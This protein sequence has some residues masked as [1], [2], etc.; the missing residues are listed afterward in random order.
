MAPN[1]LSF[2]SVNAWN[3]IYSRRDGSPALPKDPIFF[4]EMLVDRETMTVANDF[5]HCRIRRSMAPAFSSRSMLEQEPILKKNVDLLIQ[6][7][8]KRSKEGSPIDLRIWYNYTTFDL[9]GDLAFGETF[10]CLEDSSCHEWVQFVLDYFYSATLLQ[11]VHRFYPLNKALY[12]LLPATLLENR[13]RHTCMALEKVRRRIRTKSSRPDFI[14]HMLK[15][16]EANL[17]TITE[18]E[19]QASIIILAGGETSS[20]ALTFATYYLCKNPEVLTKLHAEVRAKYSGENDITPQSV[21]QLPYLNA[22]IQEALRLHPPICNGFPRETPEEGAIIDNHFVPGGMTVNLSH[23]TAYHS[24]DHFA[25]PDDFIPE[26]WLESSD[27]RFDNDTKKVFQPFS[28]GPRNCIAKKFAYDSMKF[29]LAKIIWKFDLELAAESGNW[30]E[31]QPAFVSWH[32]P[33][34]MIVLKARSS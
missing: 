5:D 23:F 34:L 32:Q 30:I 20:V 15:S 1:E 27:A 8:K 10:G 19:K 6:Q 25:R 18:V 11:V 12:L 22:I 28:V 9:I 21:N 3:D 31:K 14:S 16:A 33:P 4:N 24:P 26:R 17:I 29:I 7:L 13:R 2:I